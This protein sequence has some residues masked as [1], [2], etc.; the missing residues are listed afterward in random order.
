MLLNFITWNV[1]PILFQLGPIAVRWYGL[2]WALGIYLTLLITQKIFKNEGLP[3]EWIDKLFMYTVIGAIAGARLGHC[4]FYEWKALKEPVEFIGITFKYG[5]SYFT[6]PWELLY[7][8]Q[9]GLASHGGAL[10]ILIAMILYNKNVSKKGLSWIFDRL[11]VGVTLC[12]ASIRFGNLMNSEIYGSQTDLPWGFIFVRTGETVPMHPTQ[13]YEIIYC[14]I[15]FGVL[16]WMYWKKEAYKING[17]IF[18][19]FLIGVFGSRFCLEFIKNNQEA[20]ESYLPLNMGQIL[21]LPLIITGIILLIRSY[22]LAQ[23]AR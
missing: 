13:I 3:D 23:A 8:W 1:D 14:L 17:L 6:H 21:S 2:S 15:T 4:F 11:L 9:G 16:Y 18:G 10:G 20:F 19:T 22:K 7:V 5:N 12:G